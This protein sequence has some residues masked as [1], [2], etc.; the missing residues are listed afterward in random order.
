MSDFRLVSPQF[1][2]TDMDSKEKMIKDIL[3]RGKIVRFTNTINGITKDVNE[4]NAD[5]DGDLIAFRH[6]GLTPYIC[7]KASQYSI[8]EI[9]E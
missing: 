7:W 6:T 3:S 8:S 4:W 9:D 2:E 5:S 1:L